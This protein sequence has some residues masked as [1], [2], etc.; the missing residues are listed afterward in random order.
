MTIATTAQLTKAEFNQFRIFIYDISGIT[1][2]EGKLPLLSNRLRKRLKALQLGSFSD[3][4]E[5]LQTQG[6]D[7]EEFPQFLDSVTEPIDQRRLVN[8][9]R[10]HG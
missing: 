6:V 10:R 5:L 2:E 3:Y 4:Y 8:L 1:L 7:G 9:R